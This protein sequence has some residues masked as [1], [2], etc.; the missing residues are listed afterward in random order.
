MFCDWLWLNSLRDNV[1]SDFV[2]VP[3]FLLNHCTSTGIVK[4][5]L[6]F[7]ARRSRRPFVGKQ[8]HLVHCNQI[9]ATV[10][11]LTSQK[12]CSYGNF[13]EYIHCNSNYINISLYKLM[14]YHQPYSSKG[15]IF[16]HLNILNFLTLIFT[17]FYNLYGTFSHICLFLLLKVTLELKRSCP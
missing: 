7:F 9:S 16:L 14:I 13:S 5:Y 6:H 15:K 17:S 11:N 10:V 1:L 2:V 12:F 3:I 8:S 4:I